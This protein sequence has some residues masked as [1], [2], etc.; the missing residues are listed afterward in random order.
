MFSHDQ[1]LAE[2]LRQLN[3]GEITSTMIARCLKIPTSRVS[4]MKKGIRRIQSAEMSKLVEI[5]GMEAATRNPD[6]EL[7]EIF[8]KIE[9]KTQ[10]IRVL[11]AL[12]NEIKDI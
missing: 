9:D 7:F 4:E 11:K 10:A 3:D 12:V 8:S 6:T 2:M 1:I 5:L